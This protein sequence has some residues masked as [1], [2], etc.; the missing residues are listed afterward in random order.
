MGCGQRRGLSGTLR[1]ARGLPEPVG[2]LVRGEDTQRVQRW[3][4]LSAIGC[5]LRGEEG[6]LGQVKHRAAA[7]SG[8]WSGRVVRIP[9][10]CPWC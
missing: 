5:F 6:R 2:C 9:G 10:P 4:P 7:D 1:G 3:G 8:S